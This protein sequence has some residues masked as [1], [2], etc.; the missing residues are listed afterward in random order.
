MKAAAF[1]SHEVEGYGALLLQSSCILQAVPGSGNDSNVFKMSL[2]TGGRRKRLCL[3][4]AQMQQA[5]GLREV[6]DPTEKAGGHW[7]GST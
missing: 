4:T 2:G 7:L 5:F 3:P 1:L 6:T